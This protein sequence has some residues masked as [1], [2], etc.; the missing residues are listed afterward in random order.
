[1]HPFGFRYILIFCVLFVAGVGVSCRKQ[2][3]FPAEVA[4]ALDEAGDN[5]AEL[6]KVLNHYAKDSLKLRAAQYLIAHMSRAY[7]LKSSVFESFSAVFDSLALYKNTLLIS[8]NQLKNKE[9]RR[10]Y[11]EALWAKHQRIAG[12]PAKSVFELQSDLK[13]IPAEM[14]IQNI[15][16]AFK[17]WE[18]PWAKQYSFDQFC[19]YILP[20]R[21]YDEVPEAWRANYFKALSPLLDSLRTETDPLVVARAINNWV[22][23]DFWFCDN[24]KTF[25]RGALKANDLLKGR[26][27]AH[28]TDQV[29]LGNSLMRAAGIATSKIWIPTWG[30]TSAGH[31]VTAILS[32]SNKWH[33]VEVGDGAISDA[34]SQLRAPKLFLATPGVATPTLPTDPVGQ[35]FSVLNGFTDVTDQY[36]AVGDVTVLLPDTLKAK[37]L[38][39]CTFRSPGW[40]PVIF[41][42]VVNHKATFRNMGRKMIYLPSVADPKGELKPV[43]PPIWVDSAGVVKSLGPS[44]GRFE[45]TFYRKYNSSRRGSKVAR[46]QALLGGRFQAANRPDF[47]DAVDIHTIGPF[48]SYHPQ[49]RPVKPTEARYLRYVFPKS[50]IDIKD[51]PAQLGFYGEGKPQPAKLQGRG[52]ASAGVSPLNI[53]RLFDEDL[54]TYVS[55]TRTEPKLNIDLDEIIVDKSTDE[56][57]W[58]GLD[59]GK[60]QTVTAVE[61]C[62][63]NDKNE[64]YKGHR[65]ELFFWDNQWRSL[66]TRIAQDTF[67]SYPNVPQRALLLLKNHTEGKE[68]RIFSVIDN[69]LRWH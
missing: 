26:I 66:G 15:D 55:Y 11:Y 17:A 40:G 29:V 45:Y 52:I 38:Y 49:R 21:C 44:E 24:L 18:F 6:E 10:S 53:R 47:S 12:D 56:Y 25:K 20:Y 42:P 48:V 33:Y 14:L 2:H 16:Y 22:S 51:G 13:T 28:C 61:F 31:E 36:N 68:V 65:Y 3:Q 64:I 30:T 54:L 27:A 19:K 7:Y 57:V 43:A 60:K 5:R 8:G 50:S 58:V 62:P 34:S 63:R 41:A 23:I 39:L 69:E 32:K 46:S 1:M 59:L 35:T 67:V 9:I 4:A 37:H